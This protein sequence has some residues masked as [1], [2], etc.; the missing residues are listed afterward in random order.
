[1]VQPILSSAI[2]AGPVLII[3][4]LIFINFAQIFV[5][6]SNNKRLAK[7]KFSMTDSEIRARAKLYRLI[8]SILIVIF[9]IGFIV[10]LLDYRFFVN[11]Y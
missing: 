11:T 2:V 6:R 8:G 1:M 3:M 10:A 7:G 9:L 5:M 4:G